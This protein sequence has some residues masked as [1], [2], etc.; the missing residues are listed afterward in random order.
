MLVPGYVVQWIR[1]AGRDTDSQIPTWYYL[2]DRTKIT[3]KVDRAFCLRLVKEIGRT[4]GDEETNSESKVATIYFWSPVPGESVAHIKDV[5]SGTWTENTLKSAN[6]AT[7]SLDWWNRVSGNP[8]GFANRDIVQ[9][10][11]MSIFKYGKE[12]NWIKQF[13]RN[14][15]GLIFF[16]YHNS[17]RLPYSWKWQQD[18]I[19]N[20][21][22]A[23]EK[24]DN[25]V[26][27]IKGKFTST[28]TLAQTFF[29]NVSQ[30]GIS[31]VA[32]VYLISSYL[33]GQTYASAGSIPRPR[34]QPAPQP[35]AP[36]PV[37]QKVVEPTDP[38]TEPSETTPAENS[39]SSYFGLK[40]PLVMPQPSAIGSQ[41]TDLE[42]ARAFKTRQAS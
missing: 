19:V 25:L 12:Y 34:P 26:K 16:T 6:A 39:P 38:A 42:K 37:V 3:G 24:W 4:F 5:T 27:D 22:T 10:K 8:H 33:T 23:F 41:T 20:F 2:F 35:P 13:P 32:D 21:P 14:N 40:A 11:G 9:L 15:A 36:E 7:L 28:N 31:K 29:N 17:N 30:V 1:V 18:S